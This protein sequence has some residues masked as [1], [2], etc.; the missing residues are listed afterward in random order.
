[1]IQ[2][3]TPDVAGR[4]RGDA[5]GRPVRRR[6][7][8]LRL[9]KAARPGT[10][11]RL[12]GSYARSTAGRI[13]P[14]AT[15]SRRRDVRL[16][17]RRGPHVA[18]PL[19][20]N[21]EQDW[22]SPLPFESGQI[23]PGFVVD[24]NYAVG[25]AEVGHQVFGGN[26]R[27]TW[28]VGARNRIENTLNY[29]YDKQDF[30]RSFVDSI[31]GDQVFS[32]GLEL[33]PK[34]SSFYEDLRMVSKFERGGDHELSHGRR[35]H[36]RQDEG[37]STRVRRATADVSVPEHSQRRRHP[38]RRGPRVR[39]RAH[40]HRRVRARRVDAQVVAHRRGRRTLRCGLGR[41]RDRSRPAQRPDAGQGLEGGLRLSGDLAAPCASCPRE[42]STGSR[43]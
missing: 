1:M 43:P 38:G 6:P 17:A 31:F 35:A 30:V 10:D 34:E 26:T 12:T 23:T 13:A 41:P 14:R 15:W 37:G 25:G 16:L 40:L 42:A 3:F 32:N 19:R 24:R 28:P 8:Q 9:G 29:T 18:R 22:G 36:A 21:D 2:V 11:L 27:L 5:R 20:L 4:R 7:R 33:E 39:G